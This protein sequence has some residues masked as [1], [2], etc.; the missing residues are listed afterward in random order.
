MVSGA[1]WGI[2]W[3]IEGRVEEAKDSAVG[4]ATAAQA[5]DAMARD[6]LAA[7]RLHVAET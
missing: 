7:H 2:W 5:L 4:T 1:L 6:E 3:R